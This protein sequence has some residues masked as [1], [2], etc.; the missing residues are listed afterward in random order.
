MGATILKIDT[1][2]KKPLSEK[3]KEVFKRL[4]AL[5]LCQMRSLG[6]IIKSTNG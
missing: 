2:I 5:Q 1:S 3:Q 4:E 6:N